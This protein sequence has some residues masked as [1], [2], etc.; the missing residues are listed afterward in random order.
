MIRC[1]NNYIINQTE[2]EMYFFLNDYNDICIPEILDALKGALDEKNP[3]YSFDTHTENAICLIKN[4]IQYKNAEIH[5]VPGGT[6]ANILGA[7]AGLRPEESILSATSG[8]IEGHEAGSIEATGVKIE[9][10]PTIDGKLTVEL[11]ENKLSDFGP[12]FMT[13]PRTVYISNTSELGT[14]YTKE[15]IESIYNFCKLNGLYLFIDGARMAAALVSEKANLKLEDLPRICD[16]FTLGGTKNGMLLG[17]AI[18]IVN[19]ELKRGFINLKKQKGAMLAKGFVTGIMFETVFAMEDGYLKGARHAH[20]MAEKLAKGL[21]E[22]GIELYQE[23]Q[24]NQIFIERTK[25]EVEELRKVAA[26][27]VTGKTEAGN[28]VIRFVTT[29]RTTEEEVEGLIEII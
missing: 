8:H 9:T 4:A 12:E 20:K 1:Y 13:V 28:D 5:F 2:V 18:V 19:D 14:I 7:T 21:E 16:S 24:S 17:E 22:K 15:E 25:T 27:E 10:I 26:F 23:F 3:G 29:Y 11:L 6:S